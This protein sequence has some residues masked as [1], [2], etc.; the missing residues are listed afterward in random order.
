MKKHPDAIAWEKWIKSLEGQSCLNNL[1]TA[2]AFLEYR[3]YRAFMAG[4]KKK[5]IKK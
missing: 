5:P 1:P 2:I 4:R 3:L